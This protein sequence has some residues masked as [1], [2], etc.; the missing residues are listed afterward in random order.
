MAQMNMAS[1]DRPDLPC[2][3]PIGSWDLDVGSPT[4][5][6]AAIDS[7]RACPRLAACRELRD[8][9]YPAP[10]RPAGVIWAGIAYGDN[11]RPLTIDQLHR[12]GARGAAVLSDAS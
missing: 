1:P 5:W 6:V 12:R 9:L 8:A 7:C 4:A 3:Q 11:S 10:R 2:E